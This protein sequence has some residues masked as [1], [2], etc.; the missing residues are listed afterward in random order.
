MV[1]NFGYLV[2]NDIFKAN[3]SRKTITILFWN[4]HGI[5]N[6]LHDYNSFL[7]FAFLC[8]SETW[9]SSQFKNPPTFFSDYNCYF[10]NATK[11]KIK[12]RP[13]GGLLTLCKKSFVTEVVA[14]CEFWSF[15]L[16]KV[17]PSLII[18]SI[19]F[20]P[21][22]ELD[23]ILENL[24]SVLEDLKF[25]YDNHMIVIGG[26]F[27]CRV[28]SLDQCINEFT[29]YSQLFKYR[30]STDKV[31]NTK[32]S[33]LMSFMDE[34]SFLLLNGRTISDNP[35]NFTFV[36]P[37][38]MSVNDLIWT[39]VDLLT[40]VGDLIVSDIVTTTSDHLPLKIRTAN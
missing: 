17:S 34:N 22:I 14:S 19:Y 21:S 13:S 26:D 10:S 15:H 40:L 9:L 6:F 31:H 7:G 2:N 23:K 29:E 8:L 4:V 5:D 39:D 30:S 37:V 35:A 3:Y 25:K 20:K 36:S 33:K 16:V 38:G 28:G 32:G 18:G 12:G 24:A 27:N 11:E 1:D